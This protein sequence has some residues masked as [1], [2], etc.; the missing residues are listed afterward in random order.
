MVTKGPSN[1]DLTALHDA[2]HFSTQAATVTCA[3]ISE[4]CT[5][6][7]ST[8]TSRLS[9]T[10]PPSRSRS[11]GLFRSGTTVMSSSKALGFYP[12]PCRK[13]VSG[14]QLCPHLLSGQ[15]DGLV[16]RSMP[17]QKVSERQQHDSC[18]TLI[19]M[20]IHR[21]AWGCRADY[22]LIFSALTRPSPA[23]MR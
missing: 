19:A 22:H 5:V 16:R 12:K 2:W 20:Q 8:W 6:H 13:K 1:D 14:A 18:R 7:L 23:E 21:A 4:P 17:G 15:S 10:S 3:R 9:K 11:S